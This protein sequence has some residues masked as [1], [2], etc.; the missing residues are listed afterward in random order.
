MWCL[1]RVEE[2]DRPREGPNLRKYAQFDLT[3]DKDPKTTA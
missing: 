1:E 3:D 2:V